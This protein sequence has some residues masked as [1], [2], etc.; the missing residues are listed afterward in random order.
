MY[1]RITLTTDFSEASHSA[2]LHALALALRHHSILDILHVRDPNDD[3]HWLE[4]PQVR[5]TL[6][7][8]GVPGLPSVLDRNAT[9]AGMRINK[10]DVPSNDAAHS[11]AS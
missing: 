2:F 10:V 5:A 1:Q 6:Q 11:L 7:A 8:W 9:V 4:F 3:A